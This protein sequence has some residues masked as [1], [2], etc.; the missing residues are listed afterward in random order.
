MRGDQGFIRVARW[1]LRMAIS[2]NVPRLVDK[3]E[4]RG[5]AGVSDT[6]TDVVSFESSP[7]GV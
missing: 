5:K 4:V 7:D 3:E 1:K 6:D 2:C